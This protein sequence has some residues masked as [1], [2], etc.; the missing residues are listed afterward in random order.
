MFNLKFLG[1]VGLSYKNVSSGFTISQTAGSN[2]E[3]LYNLLIEVKDDG[4][5]L[6]ARTPLIL[7]RSVR[8]LFS[9]RERTK[10]SRCAASRL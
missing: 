3:L 6:N 8:E 5:S 2:E 4:H 7:F 9:I 1:I 10:T